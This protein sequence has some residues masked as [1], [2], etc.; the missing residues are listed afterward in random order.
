M[1]EEILGQRELEAHIASWTLIPSTGGVFEFTVDGDLLYSK[2]ATG[3]H[4]APG[5]IRQL[6]T[7]K[8]AQLQQQS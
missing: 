4:A 7:D 2:R 5:E 8:I 6:L 1:T 3:R